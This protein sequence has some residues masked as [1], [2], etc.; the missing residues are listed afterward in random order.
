MTDEPKGHADCIIHVVHNF[1]NPYVMLSRETVND[2][3]LSWAARG[4]LA[5]LLSKPDDWMVRMRD[6]ERQS[7][8]GYQAT[9]TILRELMAHGYV[10]RERK[11]G[12]NK[13][14][15]V[16]ETTV[17]EVPIMP[18]TIDGPTI[19]P[20]TTNGQAGDIPSS[21]STNYQ[22]GMSTSLLA[23]SGAEDVQPAEP[24]PVALTAGVLFD[25]AEPEQT[26]VSR[27]NGSSKAKGQVTSR[28]QS[29]DDG[30][31]D[32]RALFGA[33]VE[34]CRLDA[35][36]MRGPLN[37]TIKRLSLAEVPPTP[38][39]VRALYGREGPWYTS[40]WRGDKR[41][42][43]TLAQ[44]VSELVK[45]RSALGARAQAEEQVKGAGRW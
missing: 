16:W 42:A 43:P 38:A 28:A 22:T 34:V 41:P 3:T 8:V 12:P 37:Q 23:P 33:L 45:L 30:R 39:E 5:Y 19:P 40:D 1:E 2:S 14:R 27:G 11:V 15:F 20:S 32:R 7:P 25:Q 24:E 13:G 36:A 17:Y 4:M 29:P 44:V 26:P 18:E 10:K 21:D 35:G 9:A 31:L 6:L